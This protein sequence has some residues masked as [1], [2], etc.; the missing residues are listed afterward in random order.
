MH[1]TSICYSLADQDFGST[2]SLGIF[3]VS[4]ELLRGLSA[5]RGVDI[6][7]LSNCHAG[8]Y[9]ADIRSI[10]CR[11]LMQPISGKAMRILWDQWRVY[12]EAKKTAR[13]WLFLPKGFASFVRPC[14]LKLAVYIHDMMP[15]I[16]NELYP[17][18]YDPIVQ[19]YFDLT[20]AAT[21]RGS[22]IVF[23]NTNFTRSEIERWC[24]GKKIAVPPIIVA[25]Y[26]ITSSSTPLPK[27]DAIL[28]Y[29]RNAPHKRTD[30]ALSF[31]ERWTREKAYG[32]AVV[33]LGSVPQTASF[34]ANPK[35]VLYNRVSGERHREL[36]A[37]S[38]AAVHFSGYE[39]FGMSPVEAVIAGTPGVYS[40]IPAQ[41]EVMD[42][43][44]FAFS[45][46]SYDSFA[47]A[48]DMALA[49]SS[50][51]IAAWADILSA[52]YSWTGAARIIADALRKEEGL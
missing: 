14:P 34:P 1:T 25:G 15:V 51:T 2:N 46:Q 49:A 50:E 43:C 30:L 24:G 36:L 8:G 44:G 42:G 17:G 7:V 26:G 35:W 11:E 41:R 3:N 18:T 20:Y 28:M 47:S 48:M 37:A 13:Q 10:E 9:I 16:Y 21:L 23:T 39:G 40:D 38:R 19:R 31:M 5:L 27:Q 4:F 45:N 52:K 12:S 33:C 29:V 32:G 22:R 6:T